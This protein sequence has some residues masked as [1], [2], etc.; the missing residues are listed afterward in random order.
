MKTHTEAA[1][2]QQ[3]H[4]FNSFALAFGVFGFVAILSCPCALLVGLSYRSDADKL[5]ALMTFAPFVLTAAFILLFARPY[6]VDDQQGASLRRIRN[7]SLSIWLASMTLAFFI[8]TEMHRIL[9]Y[10]YFSWRSLLLGIVLWITGVC[11]GL[12]LITLGS[13]SNLQKR[14]ELLNS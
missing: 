6:I 8:I 2:E 7:W 3:E 1:K 11:G 13:K 9:D 4:A 5:F 14:D 12:W 10:S